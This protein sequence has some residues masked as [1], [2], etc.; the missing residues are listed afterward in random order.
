MGRSVNTTKGKKKVVQG[1]PSSPESD[2]VEPEYE[3]EKVVDWR[4]VNGKVEYLLK[5]IGYDN[6]D[7]TWEPVE[8][9]ECHELIAEFEKKRKENDQEKKKSSESK[10]K[11]SD[12]MKAKK[13]NE[14]KTKKQ[15]EGKEKKHAASNKDRDK[16]PGEMA[17]GRKE[18][19]EISHTSILKENEQD[20]EPEVIIGATDNFHKG[21][22]AFLV[23]WK[24]NDT[25]EFVLA[26]RANVLWPQMVIKFYESRLQWSS[27]AK[28]GEE[29]DALE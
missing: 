29:I 27:N 12:E 11:K 15:V 16:Q 8:A 5:W 13:S 18:A 3:V 28:E 22:L 7:N 9:L 6:D 24:F 23:K 17:H 14:M 26:S 10:T 20:Q 2:H 4:E 21:E 19:E 1:K 25:P